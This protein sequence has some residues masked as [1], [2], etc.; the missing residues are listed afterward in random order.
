MKLLQI[1]VT[2]DD[3]CNMKPTDENIDKMLDEVL[4]AIDTVVDNVGTK[5]QVELGV[6]ED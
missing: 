4:S 2:V 5:Y 1:T 3:W 6:N